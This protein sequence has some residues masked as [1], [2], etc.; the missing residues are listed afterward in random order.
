MGYNGHIIY[1]VYLKDQKKVIQVKDF[2]IFEDYESKFSTEFPDYSIGIPTFQGFLLADKYNKQLKDLLLTCVGQKA[3]VVEIANQSPPPCNKSQKVKDVELIPLI[4]TILTSRGR[5]VEDTELHAEDA[6]KK[7]HTSRTIKLS[8]KT[9]YAKKI[10][11]NPLKTFL[12]EQSLE[13]KNL[14]I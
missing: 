14:I 9:K 6:M 12:L 7:T 1:R 4:V 11:S 8:T 5:K 3:K 2:C 13:I 10:L